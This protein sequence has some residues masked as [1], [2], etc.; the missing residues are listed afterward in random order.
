MVVLCF[1]YCVRWCVDG[2]S[3]WLCCHFLVP[4]M[5]TVVAVLMVV[6]LAIFYV[7]AIYVLF[8][9]VTGQ[10][11][12]ILG[13]SLFSRLHETVRRLFQEA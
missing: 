6:V 4:S 10:S 3:T 2:C 8:R 11:C 5:F 12:F 9:V 7:R 13:R 1:S